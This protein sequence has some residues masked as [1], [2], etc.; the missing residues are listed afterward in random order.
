MSDII[1]GDDPKKVAKWFKLFE[2][3][4]WIPR[5]N[6][7]WEETR[8]HPMARLQTVLDSKIVSVKDF[9]T[10]PKNIFLAHEMIAQLDGSTVIKFTV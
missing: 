7:N 4:A 1:L 9:F 3:P 6:V 8:A 2:D 10:D 5:Y